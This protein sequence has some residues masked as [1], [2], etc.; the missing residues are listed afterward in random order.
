MTETG[1]KMAAG[2]ARKSTHQKKQSKSTKTP[3]V[4]EIDAKV[5]Y[6]PDQQ[7]LISRSIRQLEVL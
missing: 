1:E 5:S 7:I 6:L 2:K 3:K 4:I